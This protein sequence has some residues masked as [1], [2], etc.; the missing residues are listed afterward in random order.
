MDSD[1]IA[2]ISG[3]M[4][5]TI[6]RHV[7]LVRL[8]KASAWEIFY[9]LSS[10]VVAFPSCTTIY[11]VLRR[12]NVPQSIDDGIVSHREEKKSREHSAKVRLF[13]SIFSIEFQENPL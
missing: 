9:W 5:E 6:L 13:S 2:K 12:L 11:F 8:D 4:L 7:G 1:H 10:E 3:G